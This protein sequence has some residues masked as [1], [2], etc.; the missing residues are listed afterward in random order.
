MKIA[1]DNQIFS[2]QEYGGISRYFVNL[3]QQL[4]NSEVQTKIFAPIFYNKYIK[5]IPKELIFGKYLNKYPVKTYRFINLF[6]KYLSNHM[7]KKWKA[8]IIHETYYSSIDFQSKKILKVITVYDMIHEIFLNKFFKENDATI[9]KKVNSIKRADHIIAISENTKKDLITF[10]PETESKISVIRLGF[11]PVVFN[12]KN[13]KLDIKLHT[14]YILYVGD[15]GYLKNFNN[16]VIAFSNS[17]F[18]KEKY[19]IVVF[20]NNKINKKERD[21][22]NKYNILNN[23]IFDSG[24]DNLLTSYYSNAAAFI[25]PS[26]YEGFGLPLLEAMGNKCPVI[27]SNTSSMPEVAGD[28]ALFFDPYNLKDIQIKIEKLLKDNKLRS[29]MISK[30]IDRHKFFSW[31]KNAD[32][33]IKVYKKIIR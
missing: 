9:I 7:I 1:F 15:R 23:I 19:K 10:F 14:P 6:S 3:I 17:K 30:G 33:T 26:L 11:N 32:E 5:E 16:F 8:D 29:R 27:C 2:L 24:A 28:A 13:K 12:Q 4:E 31:K 20:G 25:Y 21:F 22:F 18:L